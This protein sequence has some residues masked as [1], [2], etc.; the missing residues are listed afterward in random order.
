SGMVLQDVVLYFNE[1]WMDINA[2]LAA[3]FIGDM[4]SEEV[5]KGIDERRAQLAQAAGDANWQ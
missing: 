2:D 1:Q 3:M 5:L 4:T